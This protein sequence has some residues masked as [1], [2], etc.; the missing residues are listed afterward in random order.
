MKKLYV[1]C[2]IT[3]A[4]VAFDI[5]VF[6]ATSA[7]AQVTP[8]ELLHVERVTFTDRGGAAPMHDPMIGFQCVS[9]ASNGAQCF[10]ASGW[11]T[12]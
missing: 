1:L 3:L 6:H 5:L 2:I 11:V 9:D 10:V 7:K 12:R 4:A 8:P